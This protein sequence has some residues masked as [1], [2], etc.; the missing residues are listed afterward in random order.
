M[1]QILDFLAYSVTEDGRVWSDL[2][3]RWLKLCI[4][5]NGYYIVTL[6][7]NNKPYTKA[8]HRL[9]LETFIGLCY[10]KM[11]C[12]HNDGNKLNNCLSNLRWGTRSENNKDTIKHGTRVDNRGEKHGMAKLNDS[13][14]RI[15]KY[16]LKFN[17]LARREIGKIFD[18]SYQT[19][20]LI[21]HG[22][23]WSHIL[24]P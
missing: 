5:S 21:K 19:I 24:Q 14:V 4:N 23:I 7:K 1:K 20:S 2:S 16:L 17:D 22:K 10:E 15:I 11:E 6:Q 8:V 3:N 18:V 9:V 13:Q 12:C